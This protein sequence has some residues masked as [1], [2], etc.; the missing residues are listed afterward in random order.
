MNKNMPQ[1]YVGR[2]N[3]LQLNLNF[4]EWCF[5]YQEKMKLL[6]NH[7]YKVL[8][9]QMLNFE[10]CHKLKQHD[11]NLMDPLNTAVVVSLVVL[12]PCLQVTV[13]TLLLLSFLACR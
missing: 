8:I 12:L 6:Q 13:T 3:C 2:L 10:L 5:Y 9:Y 1:W 7:L 11:N 4:E